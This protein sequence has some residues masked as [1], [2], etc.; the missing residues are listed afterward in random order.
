MDCHMDVTKQTLMQSLFV[1]FIKW[2]PLYSQPYYQ[3][4]IKIAIIV[5]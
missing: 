1:L 2:F 5:T 4:T 3:N